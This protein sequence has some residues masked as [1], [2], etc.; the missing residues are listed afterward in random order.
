MMGLLGPLYGGGF[1]VAFRQL[2]LVTSCC[3]RHQHCCCLGCRRSW[4]F[5]MFLARGLPEAY[6]RH[7]GA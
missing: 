4:Y 5:L 3:R 2:A 6:L 7:G 1:W